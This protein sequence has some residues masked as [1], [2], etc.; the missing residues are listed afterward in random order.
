MNKL[1]I[2]TDKRLDDFEFKLAKVEADT[3]WKIIEYEK[4]LEA[5]PTL[6]YVKSAMDEVARNALTEARVY[7]DGELAKIKPGNENNIT[8][9]FN[10]F[11]ETT[12]DAMENYDK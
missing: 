4:L 7:T 10:A 12:E 3:K 6:Q 2:K 9:I 1:S 5:R 11:K 8:E